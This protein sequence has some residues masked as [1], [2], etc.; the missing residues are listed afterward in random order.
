MSFLNQLKTQA[1]AVE[2][3]RFENSQQLDEYTQG[4][5]K[6]CDLLLYYLQDLARQLNVLEPAA[7]AF[8]LDGKT[9]W[10]QMKF[11]QFHVDARRRMLRNKEVFD[12]IAMGW[13]IV[14]QIGK[15]VGGMVS[16]NFPPDLKRV[17]DRLAIG[18]IKHERKELRHPEKNTLQALQFHYTTATRGSIS[19]V[20]DHDSGNLVFRLVNTSGFDLAELKYP[21]DRINHDLLDEMAKRVVGQASR[22]V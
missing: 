9:P 6:A 13:D 19:A 17:E 11:T 15:P 10:P 3:L 16:V 2:S 18:Q 4:L 7:P 14:P 8:T 20:A 22:F 12:N 1:K 21:A 5:Q